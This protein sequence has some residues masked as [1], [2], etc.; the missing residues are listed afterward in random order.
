LTS[1]RAAAKF[2][3]F[4]LETILTYREARRAPQI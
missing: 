1:R 3:I 4:A 2:I